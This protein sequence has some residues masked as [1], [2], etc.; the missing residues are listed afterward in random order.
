MADGSELVPIEDPQ[1]PKTRV[2]MDAIAS[3]LLLAEGK[4][5]EWGSLKPGKVVEEI[6]IT[7]LEAHPSNNIY[8]N[9]GTTSNYHILYEDITRRGQQEPII[10]IRGVRGQKHT[11]IS[12]QR[13]WQVLGQS[14]AKTCRVIFA[15]RKLEEGLEQDFALIM[16]NLTQREESRT[17]KA[18]TLFAAFPDIERQFRE[19]LRAS[20]ATGGQVKY[21]HGDIT[22][23]R[24][25][26]F[27]RSSADDAQKV[28]EA[29]RTIVA[30]SMRKEKSN[31][32]IA[33]EVMCQKLRKGVERLIIRTMSG[34]NKATQ[35][36]AKEFLSRRSKN[37]FGRDD[38]K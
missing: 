22:P 4:P 6:P 16:A 23:Q 5:K 26:N 21:A 32:K 11:I 27:Y 36:W 37:L 33:N 13:R 20:Q 15:T 29:G 14:G 31:G 7:S 28:M 3:V 17:T 25:A 10:A 18:K 34:Q 12:G 24:V 38:G 19:Q 35:Q 30:K 1:H 2:R 9:G 8:F